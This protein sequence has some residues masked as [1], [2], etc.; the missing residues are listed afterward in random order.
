MAIIVGDKYLID[1]DKYN[2]ILKEKRVSN[3]DHHLS[4]SSETKEHFVDI[5][6]FGKIEHLI[7]SLLNRDLKSYEINSLDDLKQT[8]KQMENKLKIEINKCS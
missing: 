7:N 2:W 1:S 4:K 5:G 3:P 8:L 6:Y